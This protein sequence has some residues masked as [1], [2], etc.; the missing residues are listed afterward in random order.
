[1]DILK[2][3]AEDFRAFKLAFSDSQH[4]M[5]T[6]LANRMISNVLFGNDNKLTLLGFVLRDAAQANLRADQVGGSAPKDVADATGELIDSCEKALSSRGLDLLSVWQAEYKY[7]DAIRK[8]FLSEQE[9]SA[10][11]DNHEFTRDAIVYLYKQFLLNDKELGEPGTIVPRGCFNEASRILA[12][13]GAD[14]REIPLIAILMATN[15]L[16][17]YVERH[18]V[19][20]GQEAEAKYV[21]AIKKKFQ[22]MLKPVAPLLDVNKYPTLD[23]IAGASTD[24]LGAILL[25]WRREFIRFME[26]SG[27][28]R[29]KEKVALSKEARG[30]LKDSMKGAL[31]RDLFGRKGK[32]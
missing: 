23:S 8:C 2:I 21:I 30:K 4:Q 13:S 24:I 28:E 19:E 9:R 7:L 31:E 26:A 5:A 22:D 18:W 27:P 29:K 16:Y 10:Y 12:T 6:I 17:E 32:K 14:E 15:W 11:S 1:M 25:E 3:L 20:D